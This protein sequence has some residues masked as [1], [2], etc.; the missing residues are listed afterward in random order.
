MERTVLVNGMVIDGTGAARQA[1]DVLI[2]GE[3]IGAIGPSL[4]R[5]GRVVDISGRVICPGFIDMHSHSGI[6]CLADPELRPKTHQGITTEVPGVDGLGAAPVKRRHHAQWR[7]HI[8]GLDG[9]PPIEWGWERFEEYVARLNRLG[10]NIAPM[11]GHGNLRLWVMGMENRAPTADELEQMKDLL[12]RSIHEGAAGLSTGLVY[13]PQAYADLREL[14]E[15]AGVVAETETFLAVHMRFE[16]SRVLES[17]GDMIQVARETGAAIHISHFKVIGK[18][19]WGRSDAMR[20]ML[21]AARADGVDVTVDQYPYTAASTMLGALLPPWAHTGGADQLREMLRDET[22]L[23]V[24]ER[25]VGK[26]LPSWESYAAHAGWENVYISSVESTANEWCVGRNL[27]EIGREWKV[28]PFRATV[29]LLLEEHFAVGMIMFLASEED[30]GT[31]LALPDG[32]MIGTDGLLGGKPHPRVYGTYPRLLGAYCRDRGLLSLERLIQKATSIPA[33]RLRL[34]DRGVIREGAYADLVVFDSS[35]VNER[36]TYE[37]PRRYP[38]G[39]EHVFINGQPVVFGGRS[40][41]NLPGRVL[42]R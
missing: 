28:S 26:G 41:G 5:E 10:P 35:T 7:T 17:I 19:N 18:L 12:R 14:C 23:R 36:S 31:L 22:R 3:R 4:P 25:D 24:I 1:A 6:M 15:L 40:T 11:T 30:I 13:T 27:V 16:G 37:E 2:E 38:D 42:L 8:S 32:H 9:N 20:E 34:T 21:G 33:A 29:R 39:I